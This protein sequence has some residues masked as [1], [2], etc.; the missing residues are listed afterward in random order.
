MEGV[1]TVENDSVVRRI[2]VEALSERERHR[3]IVERGVGRGIVHRD[4]R[5]RE[6]CEEFLDVPDALCAGYW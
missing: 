3:V 1:R 5:L 6:S 4:W 2:D